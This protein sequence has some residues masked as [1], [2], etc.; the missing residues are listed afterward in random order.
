M[1]ALE[2]ERRLDMA[3]PTIGPVSREILAYLVKNPEAQDSLEGIAHWWL[4][5]QNV[6]RRIAEVRQAV[7]ELVAMGY[8]MRRRGADSND[9]FQIN[10]ASLAEMTALLRD[11]E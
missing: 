8:L 1:A 11:V 9:R 6:E 7:Q 4:L 3:L 10:P 5:K 2:R